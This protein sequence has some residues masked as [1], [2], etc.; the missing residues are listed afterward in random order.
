MRGLH[1]RG[2]L[3]RCL[4]GNRAALKRRWLPA[5]AMILISLSGAALSIH[6]QGS[7][8]GFVG[9]NEKLGA[10]A[11]LD[12]ELKDENGNAVT[13]RRLIHKPTILTLNYFRCAGI[14]TPLLNGL[15]Q[16]FNRINLKPGE[17]FQVITI[18]FDPTDTP[19]VA[20]QKRI[21]YLEQMKRP[22]PPAA[23]RFLTG[24]AQ[25]T[26]RIADSVGFGFRAD[27]DQFV[28]P[29]VIMILA[30]DGK[31]CRYFYGISFL[32]ADLEM[33]IR[34]AVRGRTNPAIA[35]ILAYC[36]GYDPTRNAS[37]FRM[38]RIVGAGTLLIAG[39]FVFF[40]IKGR[41]RSKN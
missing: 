4:P 35:R 27:G 14:C 38:T 30:P 17:S 34:D 24:E 21:N 11:A 12:I 31:V 2:I 8:A 40:V 20:R 16:T 18:S 39:I 6:A 7:S 15:V 1:F 29:G 22:F 28:H 9:V 13:L 37:V 33:A 5:C 41:S 10:Q 23:W 26:R 36:Y 32:P 25:N 19:E 3:S